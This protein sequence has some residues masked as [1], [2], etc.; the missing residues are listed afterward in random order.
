MAVNTFLIKSGMYQMIAVD[1]ID[2]L[3]QEYRRQMGGSVSD[4]EI[5]KLG[6]DAGAQYVCVVERTELDGISYITTSMVSVQSK[7]A[8]FSDMRELPRGERAISVIERQINTMLGISSG[9]EQPTHEPIPVS[10]P[11][12]PAYQTESGTSFNASGNT[13]TYPVDTDRRRQEPK[14]K[15]YRGVGF[16]IGGYYATDNGG[17]VD[18]IE[19]GRQVTMPNSG[20]GMHVYA[21]LIYCELIV[22]AGD[23]S[24]L[25]DTY[26]DPK[27]KLSRLSC[28]AFLKFPM[29]DIG[30]VVTLYPLYGI[31]YQK[32]SPD[33][34]YIKYADGKKYSFDGKDGR[35]SKDDMKSMWGKL[36][37]GIDI[38]EVGTLCFRFQTLYGIRLYNVYETSYLEEERENGREAKAIPGRGLTFI[39]TVGLNGRH[40]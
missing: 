11:T 7:I 6:Q 24:K 30:E 34:S 39:L 16:G 12:A 28:G 27:P 14:Q 15:I 21:D 3:A 18:F 2:L 22:S 25:E 20:A 8:E 26:A 40:Y 35:P 38:C 4:N 29:I 19:S 23:G 1:A 17:G 13:Q 10:T 37:I 33:T 9:E 5:A 31:E 36:G 32:F